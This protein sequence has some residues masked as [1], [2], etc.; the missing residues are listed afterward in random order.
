MAFHSVFCELGVLNIASQ[1]HVIQL[2]MM[3]VYPKTCSAPHHSVVEDEGLS[4]DLLRLLFERLSIAEMKKILGGSTNSSPVYSH[5]EF[6][7]A[8]STPWVRG[9]RTNRIQMVLVGASF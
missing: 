9:W 6:R 8:N 1:H 7:G 4:E 3:K 2:S 5:L